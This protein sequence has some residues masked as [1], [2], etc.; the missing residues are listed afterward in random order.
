MGFIEKFQA[1]AG[2]DKFHSKA[3]YNN[4]KPAP[5]YLRCYKCQGQGHYPSSP[6]FK[7]TDKYKND[8]QN[9]YVFGLNPK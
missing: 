8:F 6:G 4:S 7:I 3:R 5:A 2:Y 9:L 1:G